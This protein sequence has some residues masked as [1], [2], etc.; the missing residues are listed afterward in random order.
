MTL[1][2]QEEFVKDLSERLVEAGRKNVELEPYPV[3]DSQKKAMENLAEA[4]SEP[5]KKFI[6]RESSQ[7]VDSDIVSYDRS[8]DVYSGVDPVSEKKIFNLSVSR[9]VNAAIESHNVDPEAHADIREAVSSHV[10]DKNNPHEVT[11]EQVGA[12]TPEQLDAAVLKIAVGPEGSNEMT[13]YRG[14]LL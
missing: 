6:D 8:V 5:V 11:A 2:P 7:G 14:E 13:F 3:E 1:T 4:F 12:V 9:V 10:N